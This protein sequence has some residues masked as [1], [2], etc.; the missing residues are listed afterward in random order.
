MPLAGLL[1][2][3]GC[4]FYYPSVPKGRAFDYCSRMRRNARRERRL[5]RGEQE[6]DGKGDRKSDQL[7]GKSE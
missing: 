7:A 4:A 5:A 2:P 3:T 6:T 1:L